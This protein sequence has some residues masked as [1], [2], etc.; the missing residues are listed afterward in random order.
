MP[1]SGEEIAIIG[2]SCRVAGADNPAELWRSMIAGEDLQSD[3]SAR[4]SGYYDEING[5]IKEVL[6][7]KNTLQHKI[8][9][10]NV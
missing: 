6:R 3:T 7:K 8:T 10:K 9:A 4:F 1:F 5:Q 2:T